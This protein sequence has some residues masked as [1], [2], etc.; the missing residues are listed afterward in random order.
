[1]INNHS[2]APGCAEYESTTCVPTLLAQAHGTVLE[3]GP[4]C[5]SQL[6]HYDFSRITK[7]IALEPNEAFQV[8]LRNKAKKLGVEAKYVVDPA[9]GGIEF[10][11]EDWERRHAGGKVSEER[12]DCVV[13]MQVLCS[14]PTDLVE[15]CMRDVWKALDP[16]GE[17]IFWEHVANEDFVTRKIQG[18]HFSPQC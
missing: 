2:I 14:L 8:D 17:F 11:L 5:G 15:R 10:W 18:K 4:G 16:G 13:C 7:L 1:M 3:I 12:L 6:Q 9:K